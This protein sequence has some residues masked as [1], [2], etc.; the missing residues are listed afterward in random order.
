MFGP[1]GKT[2]P[3]LLKELKEVRSFDE[4]L[5]GGM[6]EIPKCKLLMPSDDELDPILRE[7]SIQ[8]GKDPAKTIITTRRRKS[9][10]S[11]IRDGF[12]PSDFCKA[13]LGMRFDDWEERQKYCDWAFAA[14]DVEK[15]V[16]MYESNKGK[17]PPPIIDTSIR[18]VEGVK[19]PVDYDWTQEDSY[20]AKSGYNFCLKTNSWASKEKQA[21]EVALDV[22]EEAERGEE[23]EGGTPQAAGK[24]QAVGGGLNIRE[25]AERPDEW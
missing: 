11:V 5:K 2:A 22:F 24:K 9:W 1:K 18:V 8:W 25:E 12:S 17:E 15:W 4:I 23:T 3:L 16:E 19:V 21:V 10:K 14:K 13:I 7:W 6:D 20:M